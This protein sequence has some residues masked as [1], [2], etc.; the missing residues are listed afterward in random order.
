MRVGP[1]VLWPCPRARS[2]FLLSLIVALLLSCSDASVE[3]GVPTSYPGGVWSPPEPTF[4][5]SVETD[6]EI[7]MSDGV[8]LVGDV[9]YP[10]DLETGERAD[11][12]FPVLLTQNPYGGNVADTV[13]SFF[14]SRGY[15]FAG[16]DVRATSRS[17]GTG[18][19]IFT[20]R[21]AQ[22]GAELVEWASTL[23]G[24][25]GEV[26]LRGC[27]WLGI[28]QLE[29]ATQLGPDSPVKA[30]IP[31]CLSGDSYR[32]TMFDNGI[33]GPTA[34]VWPGVWPDALP[35]G[36]R[37]Y[38]RDHWRSLDRVARAPAIFETG[39]PAL[40]WVGWGEGGSAGAL[41]LY[42][43]L[44]NLAAGRPLWAPMRADQPV[45]GRYQAI[46]G[47]WRHGGGLDRGIELQ[48]YDTWIKGVDAGLPTETDTPLHL[49]ELESGRWVN[50][51]TYP[52]TDRS[53]ALFLTTTAT[54][55]KSPGAEG[56]ES[57]PWVPIGSASDELEFTSAPFE[58]GATLAGPIAAAL[59]VS[60]SNTNAQ[61]LL[62][63]VDVAP[64]GTTSTI[65]HGSILGS[66]RA[67][68]P[69]RSW[70]G[71][72]GAL[73]RPYLALD[74]DV[75]L[76]PGE[77]TRLEV[78]LQ[79]TLWSIEPGHRLRLRLSSRPRVED[80]GFEIGAAP[81]GCHLTQPM[82]DTLPGGVYTIHFGADGSSLRLPLIDHGVLPASRSIVPPTARGEETLPGDW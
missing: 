64:D 60:S 38:Y 82:L 74:A 37:G 40:L 42:A 69:E 28:N 65:S 35:G 30:M 73:V 16:V 57:L 19:S 48:W 15:I 3:D 45:T 26:G 58:D 12:T 21:Q 11:G 76:V 66:R 7:A 27:S 77:P 59:E 52:I 20:P 32:D 34:T 36:D 67:L 10:M 17:G 1:R 63:L 56:Q 46:I 43:A 31:G 62:V 24:A 29:T 6:V 4:G 33:P 2:A 81:W 71:A 47:D 9:S 72:D 70:V 41:E 79:P 18:G 68:D 39:I 23:D 54:L 25:S 78:P 55:T 8:V 13:G 49:Q 75:P 53:S 61:I 44:Q 50:V 14:V 80:C 22:D 5:T 51:R